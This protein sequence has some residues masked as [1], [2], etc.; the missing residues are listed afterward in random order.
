MFVRSRL[1]ALFGCDRVTGGLVEIPAFVDR[2]CEIAA[3]QGFKVNVEYAEGRKPGSVTTW[4]RVAW[5][6]A[7]RWRDL[8]AGHH[9]PNMRH[10]YPRSVQELLWVSHWLA[11]FGIDFSEL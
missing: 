8:P 7:D 3:A 1:F 4:V 6:P 9:R 10:P 11:L 2:L 5:V